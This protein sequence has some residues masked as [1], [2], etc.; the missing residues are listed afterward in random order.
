MEPEKIE[1]IIDLEKLYL[2][3]KDLDSASKCI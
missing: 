1:N 3:I 2:I